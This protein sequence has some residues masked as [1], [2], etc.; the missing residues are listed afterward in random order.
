[1]PQAIEQEQE[2]KRLIQYGKLVT[3]LK[4][5]NSELKILEKRKYEIIHLV[6]Y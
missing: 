6:M 1:M 2:Q 5:I 3:E 4:M